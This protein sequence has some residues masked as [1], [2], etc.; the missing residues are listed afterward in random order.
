MGFIED[1]EENPTIYA[2]ALKM[3]ISRIL[4]E[5]LE[6]HLKDEPPKKKPRK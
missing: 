3:D 4:S 1:P 5:C 6:P 2:L